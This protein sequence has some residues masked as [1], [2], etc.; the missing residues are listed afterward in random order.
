MS[1][2][3]GGCNP[4]REDGVTDRRP[5]PGPCDMVARRGPVVKG[6]KLGVR[7]YEPMTKIENEEKIKF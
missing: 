1:V 7:T 4:F 3:S 6:K 2:E 5:E